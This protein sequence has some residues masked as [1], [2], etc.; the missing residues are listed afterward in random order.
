MSSLLQ[1]KSAESRYWGICLVK[2]TV[3]NGGEGTGHVVVWTK[4]LLTLLNVCHRSAKLMSRD[5][6]G[7]FFWRGLLRHLEAV[8]D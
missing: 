4:L 7:V 3:E 8:L 5:L 6:R 2:A 1:S